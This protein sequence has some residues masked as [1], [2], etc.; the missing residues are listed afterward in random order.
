MSNRGTGLQGCERVVD[1]DSADDA[2]V[3]VAIADFTAHR[4]IIEQAKGILMV[5]YSIS[6]EQAFDI[7]VWRSQETN[8]KLRR[9]AEQIVEDFTCR[10]D[11][12]SGVRARADNLLLTAHLRVKPSSDSNAC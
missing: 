2:A 1:L 5:V 7:L 12:S 3:H 11:L 4:A 10:L 6:C 8:T 9:L